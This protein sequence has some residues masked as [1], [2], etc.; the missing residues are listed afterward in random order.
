MRWIWAGIG[1]VFLGIG[2]VGIFVPL[3]PTTIF[4]I[5]AVFCLSESHPKVR[6]WI[7]E[8]PGVGPI[9][10]GLIE[11]GEMTRRSK[12]SAVGG[13]VLTGLISTWFAR[14]ALWVLLALW[15]VLLAV[16]IFILTRAAPKALP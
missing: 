15:L 10:E 11:R 12:L 13:I 1:F 2:A 14:D 3:W 5:L 6:D 8:R 16:C 7:Y 4:W 9:I